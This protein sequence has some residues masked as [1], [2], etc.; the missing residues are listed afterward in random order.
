MGIYITEQV[1][2]FVLSVLLGFGL[3]ALYDVL[4]A[5]RKRWQM[6]TAVLDIGY[7]LCL[8]GSLFL[9]TLRQAQGQLRL[10]VVLGIVGGC[11]LFFTGLS[12]WLRPVWGFWV[13]CLVLLGEIL[14]IPGKICGKIIKKL[15]NFS[16][17]LFYFGHKCSTIRYY[18]LE[19]S[20]KGG[21]CHGKSRKTEKS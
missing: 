21:R 19:Q 17:K 15:E 10:F 7:C 5:V 18:I 12:P 3:G 13:D 2:L 6:L 14:A 4:G 8:L 20:K 1:R 11:V 9:F 16:K